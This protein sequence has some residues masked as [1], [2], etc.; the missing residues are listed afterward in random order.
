MPDVFTST[1][2]RILYKVRFTPGGETYFVEAGGAVAAHQKGLGHA[3]L[4]GVRH[5]G[6]DVTH[7]TEN[8]ITD[9]YMDEEE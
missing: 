5:T 6:A 9:F 8:E 4:D 1:D 7:A 3:A 2:R